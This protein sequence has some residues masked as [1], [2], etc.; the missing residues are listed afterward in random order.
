MYLV[1]NTY[2]CKEKEKKKRKNRDRSEFILLTT[3]VN[4][5]VRITNER[6]G[7]DLAGLKFRELEW[8]RIDASI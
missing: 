1:V 4:I 7:F 5:F 6:V 2:R 8:S 3:N